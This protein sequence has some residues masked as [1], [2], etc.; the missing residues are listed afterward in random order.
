MREP[1]P[2][3]S[4]HDRRRDLREFLVSVGTARPQELADRFD[5]SLVTI[6]RDLDRLADENLVQKHHGSVTALPVSAFENNVHYRRQLAVAEKQ[7]I[8]RAAVEHIQ[9]GM[10]L[11]ADDSTTMAALVPLLQEIRPLTVITNSQD[12]ITHLMDA[13]DIQLISLGGEYSAE[14][15]AFVG[16]PCAAT[17]KSLHADLG[18][19]SFSGIGT[20]GAY[21]QDHMTVVTKRALLGIAE[22]RILLA[23]HLKLGRCALFQAAELSEFERMITDE[24]A[25]QAVVA[26]LSEQGLVVEVTPAGTE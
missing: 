16:A 5:V 12:V 1:H 15:D 19:Y 20:T 18:F 6:H 3:T 2:T 14:H 25:D 7:A 17:A 8:A 26:E 13:P 9:P 4:A 22:R 23:D 24:G 21:H 11:V 10:S